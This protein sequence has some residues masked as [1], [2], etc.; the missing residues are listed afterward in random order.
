MQICITKPNT[1]VIEYQRGGKTA[2]IFYWEAGWNEVETY[3]AF[4]RRNPRG[5][6]DNFVCYDV[7]RDADKIG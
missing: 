1:I 2:L 5:D 3:K 7:R 4:Y 6:T